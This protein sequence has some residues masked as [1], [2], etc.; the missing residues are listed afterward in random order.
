MDKQTFLKELRKALLWTFGKKE[1][2]DILGDYE[3]F[4]TSGAADGKT[5]AEICAELGETSTIALDLAETLEKKRW[6]SAKIIQRMIAAAALFCIG[7]LYYWL[8]LAR[9]GAAMSSTVLLAVTVVLWFVLGGLPPV[10]RRKSRAGKWLVLGG[11]LLL[12]G[13]TVGANNWYWSFENLMLSM[14]IDYDAQRTAQ[15]LR[16]VWVL[17]IAAALIIALLAIIGFYRL[18]PQAFTLTVHALGTVAYLNVIYAL[19]SS[20]SNVMI[21][22]RSM[23]DALDVYIFTIVLIGLCAVL[24]RYMRRRVR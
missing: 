4:F 11:H 13:M 7:L 23:W 8:Q 2:A 21:F 15:M 18:T 12:G 5:E 17:F 22:Q 9:E 16:V 19:F 20:L 1:T 10:A 6:F 14:P 3:G 24:I